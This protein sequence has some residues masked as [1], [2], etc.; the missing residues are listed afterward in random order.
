MKEMLILKASE[1]VKAAEIGNIVSQAEIYDIKSYVF[2]IDSYQKL[3]D[4]LFTPQKYDYIYLATHG[5]ET[6][7]G[8]ISGTVDISWLNFAAMICGSSV[9]KE[10]AIVFHSC[11]R[12]GLNQVAWQMFACCP[13]IE[14]VCGPRHDLYPEDLITAFNLFL[15]F[16]EIKS[17]DP[18]RSAEKVLT[19]TDVRLVCYDRIETC[20]DYSYTN[21][22]EMIKENIAAS[23]KKV[24]DHEIERFGEPKDY[25]FQ[26]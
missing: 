14:F 18:V 22:C 12:G 8:N 1:D 9:A 6:S 11:C 16:I 5:C 2:S 23:F 24:L 19:A 25:D 21:H 17:I 20:V 7:W 3:Y 15:Y 26:D 4:T 10:G 13:K